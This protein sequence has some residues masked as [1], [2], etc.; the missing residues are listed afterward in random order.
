MASALLQGMC[1]CVDSGGPPPSLPSS[2]KQQ[3]TSHTQTRFLGH[4]VEPRAGRSARVGLP[5]PGH[6]Q[7]NI[8]SLRAAPPSPERVPCSPAGSRIS[9]PIGP[10][11]RLIVKLVG[12]IVRVGLCCA[13]AFVYNPRHSA[14]THARR[15]QGREGGRSFGC[16]VHRFAVSVEDK[17]IQVSNH[18]RQRGV[19]ESR[20]VREARRRARRCVSPRPRRATV[21]MASNQ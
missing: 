18:A 4:V 11:E 17:F 5:R 12:G 13:L 16:V 20:R 6:P 8:S 19:G 7:S 14:R 10:R 15:G 2:T 1:V 21:S 9:A 3:A